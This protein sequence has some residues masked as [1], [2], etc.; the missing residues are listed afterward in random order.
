MLPPEYLGGKL[1]MKSQYF[2]IWARVVLAQNRYHHRRSSPVPSIQ[3]AESWERT[4]RRRGILPGR[5]IPAGFAR[6]ERGEEENYDPQ[7]TNDIG[8]PVC[9]SRIDYGRVQRR[10]NARWQQ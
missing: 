10:E 8:T 1:T 3:R 6:P 4:H 2:Y 9:R 5:R 7:P